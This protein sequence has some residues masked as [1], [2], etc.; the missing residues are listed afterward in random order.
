MSE[1]KDARSYRP[2]NGER[3][4]GTRAPEGASSARNP[5]SAR[6]QGMAPRTER[7]AAR[8]PARRID[9]VG[10]REEPAAHGAYGNAR[11]PAMD[12]EFEELRRMSHDQNWLGNRAATRPRRRSSRKTLLAIA[13]ICIV[14]V[15]ALAAAIALRLFG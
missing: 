5:G 9:P 1:R 10:A 6:T 11:R 3:P 4:D 14:A 2:L 12:D 13:M 15:V 7:E 8:M